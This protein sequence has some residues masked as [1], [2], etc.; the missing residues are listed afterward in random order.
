M[1]R[2][3]QPIA[4]EPDRA[5]PAAAV[6]SPD[7]DGS[8]DLGLGLR[9]RKGVVD[10]REVLVVSYP[11]EGAP[12][13]ELP[14]LTAAQSDVARMLVVGLPALDIAKRRGTSVATVTRQIAQ[15]YQRLGIGTRAE[16]VTLI[17][18][19]CRPPRP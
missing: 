7:A 2:R 9:A 5:D 15:V 19:R 1:T 4:P 10:G 13:T 18:D 6:P 17:L 11:L 16:L 8:F 14:E 3:L 12:A